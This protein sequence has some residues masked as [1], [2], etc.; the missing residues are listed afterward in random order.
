MTAVVIQEELD[1]VPLLSGE[2]RPL[3][4]AA[5]Q[6]LL[7]HCFSYYTDDM[8]V[9]TW[10]RA[11]MFEP[12]PDSDV[13]DVLEVANAQLLEMRYYDELLNDELPRMYEHVL[14]A[15]RASRLVSSRRYAG[16]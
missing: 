12:R 3:S 7:R 8:V 5:R 6:D 13:I 4:A 2:R 16:L 14:T 11:F 10:D 1:L 15:Q 9:L